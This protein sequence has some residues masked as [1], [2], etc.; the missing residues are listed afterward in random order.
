VRG[1]SFG[2]IANRDSSRVKSSR[3][4]EGFERLFL[5]LPSVEGGRLRPKGKGGAEPVS[6][7]GR[8]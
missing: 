3:E 2:S 4:G 6:V 1:G 5:H 8:S 7:L